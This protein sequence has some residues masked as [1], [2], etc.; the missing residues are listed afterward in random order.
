[1]GGYN[2]SEKGGGAATGLADQFIQSLMSG[3]QTGSFGSATAGQRQDGANPVGDTM[4]MFGIINDI[5][6]G[7]AGNIGGAYSDAIIKQGERDANA[8]RARFGVGGGTA[9]G[10]PGMNAEAMVR[11]ETAPKLTQAIG[12]LQLGAISQLLPIIAGLSSKGI[13]QREGVM[14]PSSGMQIFQ[15][16]APL[17]GAGLGA[18]AGNPLAGAGMGTTG[19]MPFEVAPLP[20]ISNNPLFSGGFGISGGS[21]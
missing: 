3:L 10:T 17:I 16:A 18:M 2:Y 9:F 7:G 21:R 8:V 1:M 6:S 14:T 19:G 11:S 20:T 15:A 5:L 12:G 13:A 4:G